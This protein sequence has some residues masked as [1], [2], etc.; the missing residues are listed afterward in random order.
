MVG[1]LRFATKK[2]ISTRI[3]LNTLPKENRKIVLGF[4]TKIIGGNYADNKI[5]RKN[6]YI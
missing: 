3:N 2:F 5:K 4:C 6:V 1:I